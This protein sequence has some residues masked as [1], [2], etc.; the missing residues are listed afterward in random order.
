MELLRCSVNE[1]KVSEGFAA[2]Y[3]NMLERTESRSLSETK[4]TEALEDAIS[5]LFMW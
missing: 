5:K 1:P 2:G 3:F 4:I